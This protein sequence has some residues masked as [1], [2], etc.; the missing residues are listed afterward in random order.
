M[1]YFYYK[2]KLYNLEKYKEESNNLYKIISCKKE[3][4]SIGIW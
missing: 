4:I 1:M 3:K 2:E